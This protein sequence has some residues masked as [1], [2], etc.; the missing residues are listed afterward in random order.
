MV[1]FF[2]QHLKTCRLSLFRKNNQGAIRYKL[3]QKETDPDSSS[4][5][6]DSGELTDAERLAKMEAESKV[7]R[8]SFAAGRQG[9]R[10][11]CIFTINRITGQP[12][13]IVIGSYT[14]DQG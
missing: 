5:D 2:T 11:L 9:D 3:K 7:V 14:D 4:T 13:G 10:E 6:S 1:P 12:I 8:D